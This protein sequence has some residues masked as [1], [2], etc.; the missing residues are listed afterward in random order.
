MKNRFLAAILCF[1]V[2]AGTLSACGNKTG[3]ESTEQAS[4]GQTEIEATAEEHEP[5]T[6]E[7]EAITYAEDVDISSLINADPAEYIK[8]PDISSV[9]VSVTKKQEVTDE[10]VEEEV[11]S[12]EDMATSLESVED[13]DTVQ[14]GDIVNI[15]YTEENEK[16]GSDTGNTYNI[17]VGAASFSDE[18]DKGLIGMKKGE[19]KTIEFKYPDDFYDT[20]LAGIDTKFTVTVNDILQYIKKEV[21]DETIKDFGLVMKDG[22]PVETMEQLQAYARESLEESAEEKYR[23]NAQSSALIAVEN[24]SESVKEFPEDMVKAV[25]AYMLAGIGMKESEVDEQMQAELDTYTKDYIREQFV[26]ELISREQNLEVTS[27]DT[28]EAMKEYFGDNA[29]ETY[30]SLGENDKYAYT[31]MAKREKAADYILSKAKIEEVD[32]EEVQEEAAS[33]SSLEEEILEEAET[34]ETK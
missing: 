3:Q 1:I 7:E 8:L 4:T 34:E 6:T 21:N 2:A 18:V 30:D 31:M 32:A 33:G 22:S 11:K 24:A 23:Y 13:R 14:E 9:T 19:T 27:T 20:D 25:R 26:V 5:G 29:Q 10:Q 17:E 15:K 16:G 12:Y 28:I